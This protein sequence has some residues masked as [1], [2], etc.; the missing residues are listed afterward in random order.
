M[1]PANVPGVP[2]VRHREI[3]HAITKALPITSSIGTV[4][5]VGSQDAEPVGAVMLGPQWK[6]ESAESLR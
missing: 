3:G 5:D 4:L 2:S 1:L 6:R